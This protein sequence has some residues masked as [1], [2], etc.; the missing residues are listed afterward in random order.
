MATG[1]DQNIKR[2]PDLTIPGIDAIPVVG[3]LLSRY[4]VIVYLA[5]LATAG[6]AL[7]FRRRFGRHVLAVGEAPLR[8]DHRRDGIAKI[9]FRSLAIAAA[10]SG[11]GKAYLS[12]G[13]LGLFSRYM[14]NG[15]GWL[16][17]TA[18]LLALNRP[19]GV[20]LAAWLFGLADA[21]SF[22]LQATTSIPPSVVQFLP[23]GAALVALIAVGV[24]TT[25]GRSLFDLL[26]GR[27]PTLVP[28]AGLPG[29]TM[30]TDVAAAVLAD[31][32]A[33]TAAPQPEDTRSPR[34]LPTPP[35]AATPT[36]P[37]DTTPHNP[38]EPQHDQNPPPRPDRCPHRGRR[39]RGGRQRRPGPRHHRPR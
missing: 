1:R 33:A 21:A 36:P 19:L 16:A 18:A 15:R 14:T 28:A 3:G 38:K 17:V 10:L 8:G 5:W 12:I 32:T 7:L 31:T 24:R 27:R 11:L 9:R 4:N 2:L 26:L 23:V 37:I 35:R 13:N 22:Q 25:Y 6:Y 34:P 29:D 30:L 20:V 39:P